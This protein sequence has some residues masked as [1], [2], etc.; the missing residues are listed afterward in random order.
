[1]IYDAFD[2]WGIASYLASYL[3]RHRVSFDLKIGL[4]QKK[5]KGKG[6]RKTSRTYFFE[7]PPGIFSFFTLATPKNSRQT[8]TSPLRNSTNLWYNTPQKFHDLKS[9]PLEIP[10]DFFWATLEIA[11]CFWLTLKTPPVISSKMSYPQ[12]SVLVFLWNSPI[13]LS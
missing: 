10:H 3:A 2:I 1:M 9:R 12:P 4:L 13:K 11:R 6:V 7:K 8:K 5:P